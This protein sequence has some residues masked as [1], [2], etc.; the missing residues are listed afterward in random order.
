MTSPTYEC[1]AHAVACERRR[2]GR[3]QR[4]ALSSLS[5]IR[6]RFDEETFVA[7]YEAIEKLAAA[8]KA[9]KKGKRK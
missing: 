2:I 1:C 3:A 9:P 8:T 5:C 6:V 7:F 4:D